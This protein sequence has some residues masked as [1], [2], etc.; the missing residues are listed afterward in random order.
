MNKK[1]SELIK[2]VLEANTEFNRAVFRVKAMLIKTVM[3]GGL[4]AAFYEMKKRFNEMAQSVGGINW[5]KCISVG[6]EKL[7][8][9]ELS[10]EIKLPELADVPM[11]GG[12]KKTFEL[13][14]GESLNCVSKMMEYL[15]RMCFKMLGKA[16]SLV[17]ALAGLTAKASQLPS[18]FAGLGPGDLMRLPGMLK[19]NVGAFSSCP[20]ILKGLFDTLRLV[21]GEMRSGLTTETPTLSLEDKTEK[22]PEQEKV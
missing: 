18:M 15:A 14:A 2:N 6:F 20:G 13:I 16:V 7:L 5:V 11:S 9:G 4:V 22:P 10:I 3:Q 21:A 1:K 12:V 17:S 19:A 8:N